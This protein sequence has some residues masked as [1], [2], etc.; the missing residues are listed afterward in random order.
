MTDLT[1]KRLTAA[2]RTLARQTFHLMA[3]VFDEA[4]APLSDAY[5]DQLLG[6]ADFWALAA[7]RGG[8]VAGGLTAHALPLTRFEAWE[9]FIYDIAV[10]PPT[11]GRAS[12]GG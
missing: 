8:E 1:I 10:A 7:M 3:E 9:L 6:R 12:G 4:R 5:L 11:S 2:D